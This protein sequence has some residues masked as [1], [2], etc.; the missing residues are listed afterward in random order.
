M[1]VQGTRVATFCGIEVCQTC[2]LVVAA[3]VHDAFVTTDLAAATAAD[4]AD[5][6]AAV[7]AAAIVCIKLSELNG[8]EGQGKRREEGKAR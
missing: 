7:V 5:I 3:A 8:R 4:V 6:V 2:L 1:G